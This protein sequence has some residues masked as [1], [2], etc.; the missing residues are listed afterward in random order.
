VALAGAGCGGDEEPASTTKAPELTVPETG[1]ETT[2]T[3]ETQTTPPPDTGTTTTNTTTSP[4]TQT[5]PQPDP[6][7][8]EGRFEKFC[9][10]NPGACG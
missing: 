1:S 9:R 3:N 2:P 7:T 10:E 8:P 4:S 5:D 6:D